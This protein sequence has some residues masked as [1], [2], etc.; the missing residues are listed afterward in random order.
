MA[1]MLGAWVVGRGA[2]GG[3]I[4]DPRVLRI[5]GTRGSAAGVDY[6]WIVAENRVPVRILCCSR[7]LLGS[8]LILCRWSKKNCC[9]RR[10]L[11]YWASCA[12]EAANKK[13]LLSLP[14]ICK[15]S[16]MKTPSMAGSGAQGKLCC[17]L[18]FFLV[19]LQ[20]RTSD[21]IT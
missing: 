16:R 21:I 2:P 15:A 19:V 11:C 20:L 6:P 18:S 13:E 7:I 17:L 5:I 9:F 3:S 1:P 12:S 8:I 14:Q 10:V 4:V